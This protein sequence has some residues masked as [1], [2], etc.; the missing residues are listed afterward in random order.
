MR[1]R[2]AL[3]DEG[4]V[5]GDDVDTR[6][7]LCRERLCVFYI[8]RGLATARRGER[9]RYAHLHTHTPKFQVQQSHIPTTS[10]SIWNLH[11]Q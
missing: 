4:V 8:P 11:A 2:H 7:A 10:T 5:D 1:K 9:A 6:D 3:D